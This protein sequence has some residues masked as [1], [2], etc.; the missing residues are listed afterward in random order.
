MPGIALGTGGTMVKSDT[1]L[2]AEIRLNKLSRAVH[3]EGFLPLPLHRPH[4][5][6]PGA[7]ILLKKGPESIL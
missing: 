1:F 2:P 5:G 3:S 4:Y 6:V 7:L